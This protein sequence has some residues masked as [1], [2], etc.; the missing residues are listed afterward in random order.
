MAHFEMATLQFI[1]D[2]MPYAAMEE[3]G[4][5]IDVLAVTV[6]TQE[7]VF[8]DDDGDNSGSNST[9]R[10][11]QRRLQHSPSESTW[12]SALQV[13]FRTVGVLTDGR[14]PQDDSWDFTEIADHGFIENYDQYLWELGSVT[15]TDF[16]TPLKAYSNGGQITSP[17]ATPEENDGK[18]PG[19]TVA[20]LLLAFLAIGIA[21][22]AS[23]F[24]IR[25]HKQKKNRRKNRKSLADKLSVNSGEGHPLS[26]TKTMSGDNDEESATA[27][28]RFLAAFTNGGHAMIDIDE[29]SLESV[30]LTPRNRVSPR[31]PGF[32]EEGMP[33][34]NLDASPTN[35]DADDNDTFFGRSTFMKKWLTP[36]RS[37]SNFSNM[38]GYSTTAKTGLFDPPENENTFVHDES[39]PQEKPNASEETSERIAGRTRSEPIH[40]LT[41]KESDDDGRSQY[42]VPIMM[43]GNG[44]EIETPLASLAPSSNYMNEKDIHNT[45]TG[46]N[47]SAGGLKESYAFSEATGIVDK[48]SNKS[49]ASHEDISTGSSKSSRRSE[50][51]ESKI[52]AFN[53]TFGTDK[54]SNTEAEPQPAVEMTLGAR[55]MSVEEEEGQDLISPPKYR[56]NM[57]TTNIKRPS[58]IGIKST[59]PGTSLIR[60]TETK[61][62]S[63]FTL[64]ARPMGMAGTLEEN[65]DEED[66]RSTL[67]SVVRRSGA[68]DVYA[69]PGPIGIVVDTSKE[70][71]SVHSL[72]ATSPMMGLITP[73]DLIVA[74]DDIDTRSMSAAALTRLMAKK[75][76]Q[77]ERKITLYSVDGY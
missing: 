51:M 60:Q 25:Q 1:K 14:V 13:E 23:Y 49:Q 45:F 34:E 52:Q 63:G 7:I 18:S 47:S 19:K 33:E 8:P 58:S 62:A 42:T 57:T 28:R 40:G 64:G 48:A 65:R 9:Q 27:S 43:F 72:K 4:Y 12:E 66:Q 75:S 67:S 24:A 69:P 74:L 61:P 11:H 26:P 37:Q 56:Y 10:R 68:Y 15:E 44:T 54:N 46:N 71:P 17:E 2:T 16:F 31:T 6:L 70:G 36:R 41:T 73:G 29:Q 21:G 76:R 5:S 77:R 3:D 35:E 30:G 55:S 39:A 59:A 20:A 38:T 22:F 53:K 50:A 32:G